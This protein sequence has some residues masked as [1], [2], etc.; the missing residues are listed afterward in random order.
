METEHAGLGTLLRAL[1]DRLDPAVE[2]TYEALP[3]PYRPR[4]TPVVQALL[5]QPSC[6]IKD[7]ADA[8]GLSHSAMSQTVSAMVRAGWLRTEAGIDGRERRLSLTDEAHA[9]V[10]QLQQRWACTAHAAR[11]LDDELAVSLERALREALAALQRRPFDARLADAAR[12][13]A[14]VPTSD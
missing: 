12:A 13:I 14:R 4:F 6:R 1:L 3:L 11:T 2:R 7:V 5:R 9:L 10:P 8:C